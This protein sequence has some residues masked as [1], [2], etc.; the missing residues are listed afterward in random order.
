M[1][2]NVA[3]SATLK[4]KQRYAGAAKLETASVAVME[5]QI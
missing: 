3:R 1:K 2:H 5:R 4:E